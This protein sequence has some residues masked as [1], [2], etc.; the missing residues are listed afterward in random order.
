M[1]DQVVKRKISEMLAEDIGDG[2]ITSNSILK[3]N[4]RASAEII[5]KQPGVLA[6]AAEAGLAF[7]QLGVAVKEA[8][9]DGSKT[10]A[11]SVVMRL[12]GPA[13]GIFAGE[14]VA[15]NLLM[16]MSGIATATHEM[17]ALAKKKNPRVLVASTRKTAPLLTRLDKWAVVMGGG[18]THRYSLSDHVLIKDGHLKLAGS[19]GGAVRRA[20]RAVRWGKV[21]VEV[22]TSGE[23]LDAVKAGADMVMFDNMAP[24]EIK[25]AV[26]LLESK[27]LRGRVLLEA[28]GGINPNNIED[29][30]ATGVDIVSSSYMTMRAPALDISLEIKK[31]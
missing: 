4:A 31:D 10:K 30:A 3:P 13:R 28:S 21:E 9:P 27:K 17:V 29:Y 14:R 11:G 7:K 25:K 23:A 2:D 20:K 5:A 12:E 26:K 19:V 8:Q 15:L 22:K 6:G 24:P 18:A 1:I 16:R